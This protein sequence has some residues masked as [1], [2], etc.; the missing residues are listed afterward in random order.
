MINADP[1]YYQRL[2]SEL[3]MQSRWFNAAITLLVVC[4]ACALEEGLTGG[5]TWL[6][7]VFFTFFLAIWARIDMQATRVLLQIYLANAK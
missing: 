6:I 1:D 3:T 7:G 2:Q 4:L 5:W